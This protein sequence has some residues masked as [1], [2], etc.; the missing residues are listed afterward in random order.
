MC[1]EFPV[2]F[3]FLDNVVSALEKA[4]VVKMDSDKGG[5]PFAEFSSASLLTL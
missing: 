1:S 5:F 4:E 3:L 2:V